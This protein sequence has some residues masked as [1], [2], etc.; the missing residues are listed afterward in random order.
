MSDNNG[1][2][3]QEPE[4][5][6]IVRVDNVA[7]DGEVFAFSAT[8][9]EREALAKRLGLLALDS[10][11]ADVTASPLLSRKQQRGPYKGIHLHVAFR[12][13]VVQFCVVT[14]EPVAAK[15]EDEFEVDFLPKGADPADIIGTESPL[16]TDGDKNSFSADGSMSVE[17]WLDDL[18]EGE[19]LIDA[20]EVDPP[21]LLVGGKVEIGDLIA[22]NLSLALD[23]YPRHESAEMEKTRAGDDGETDDKRNNPF[24]VLASL[25]TE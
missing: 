13:D 4:F 11:Q 17:E 7:E 9:K 6:R 22:E 19:I 10:L 8:E 25:K 15:V 24:A 12:A 5:S 23:P 18:E 21:E 20:D 3:N 14:L 2:A 1:N 16:T